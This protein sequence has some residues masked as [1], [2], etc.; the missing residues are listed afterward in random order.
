MKKEIQKQSQIQ[1]SA[2]A[3]PAQDAPPATTRISK[4]EGATYPPKIPEMRPRNF[5]R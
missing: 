2:F 1:R 3:N 5:K 4:P